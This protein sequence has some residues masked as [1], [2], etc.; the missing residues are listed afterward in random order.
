MLFGMNCFEDIVKLGAFGSAKDVSE[1]MAVIH[2]ASKHGELSST[3][4]SAN[5]DVKNNAK[6]GS[7][8]VL[9]LC[10]GDGCTPRTAVLASYTKKW[11]CVSIDPALSEEWQGANPK[12]I[13][14]L[15]GFGGT[16]VEFMSSS[17]LSL[18]TLSL[19][20]QSFSH[21]VLLCV[22]SH[23]R[24]VGPV[25]IELIRQ[26]Y[27]KIP[28]TVVSLPCCPKFRHKGDIG[29]EP[30]VFYD[31][32]CVFSACRKVEIWN[33][34]GCSTGSNDDAYVLCNEVTPTS[35]NNDAPP[36]SLSLQSPSD[37]T[38]ACVSEMLQACPLYSE[39][40]RHN[41]GGDVVK[42]ISVVDVEEGVL[43]HVVNVSIEY[44]TPAHSPSLPLGMIMKFLRPESPQKRMF[45]T[46]GSFYSPRNA[47]LRSSIPFGI[48]AAIHTSPCCIA[49]Q[50]I[51]GVVATKLVSGCKNKQDAENC[52]KLLATM[53]GR[54]W[55]SKDAP[56]QAK[57]A[58]Y[59]DLD[60]TPGV[61]LAMDGLTKERLFTFR[62]E[63]YLHLYASTES[64][65]NVI[66]DEDEQA[67][68]RSL[69]E[70]L[71]K[72]RIR[73][74]HCRVTAFQP[75]CIHGDFHVGNLL[76]TNNV[77]AQVQ[78]PP[79]LID[80]ATCGRGNPLF[81][82]CFFLLVSTPHGGEDEDYTTRLLQLYYTTLVSDGGCLASEAFPTFHG[83]FLDMYHDCVLNEFL[84]LV[85]YDRLARQFVEA[86]DTPL[87]KEERGRHFQQVARR[88][89]KA[90][91]AI[92]HNISLPTYKSQQDYR[93]EA[94]AMA[95]GDN[96]SAEL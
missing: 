47:A 4:A 9:C 74:I 33:Y 62:W 64:E 79:Y 25:T 12:N 35:N 15:T 81:D 30:D 27:G 57:K 36:L 67:Q 37:L 38:P 19:D 2:A 42:A 66:T 96:M 10:I 58:A 50:R 40:F 8:A 80:W 70:A 22:H 69:C 1:S 75:T 13:D 95:N 53:H 17:A 45:T 41:G 76:F 65:E 52:V 84:I 48:P 61:G 26:H 87:K 59:A 18:P 83:T 68:L 71:S 72:C 82:L 94:E 43:S 78:S 32:D 85:V 73:E 77:Q 91:L 60:H 92:Q 46:E 90:L 6:Q 39:Y 51:D 31:D 54:C 23:A 24:F 34:A 14:G 5:D 20:T 28:T 3:A 56:D 49:L 86:A 55:I 29:R 7:S 21:L 88:C 93:E 16:L 11:T 44:T 63:E 89:M